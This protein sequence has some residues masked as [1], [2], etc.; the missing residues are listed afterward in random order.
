MTKKVDQRG[1]YIQFTPALLEKSPMNS[2][3]G[4]S[5]VSLGIVS[6]FTDLGVPLVVHR[7]EID[8][9]ICF[10]FLNNPFV[11]GSRLPYYAVIAKS[12]SYFQLKLYHYQ[13]TSREIK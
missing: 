3:A 6:T 9:Y 1:C 7:L 11:A 10:N 8:T 13:W 12:R 2:R 4:V 5:H